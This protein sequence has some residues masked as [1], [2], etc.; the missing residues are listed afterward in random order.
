MA[1][2][3]SIRGQGNRGGTN[4]AENFFNRQQASGLDDV[5]RCAPPF[6]RKQGHPPIT[7]TW[8]NLQVLDQVLVGNLRF[9]NL[10]DEGEKS[11]S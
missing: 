9:S 6:A 1:K 4:L 10:S 5:A 8:D 3:R 11:L 2:C 7:E